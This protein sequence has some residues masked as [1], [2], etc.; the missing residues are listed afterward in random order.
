M[1]GLNLDVFIDICRRIMSSHHASAVYIKVHPVFTVRSLVNKRMQCRNAKGQILDHGKSFT[2]KLEITISIVF[3]LKPKTREALL[4]HR[5]FSPRDLAEAL[6]KAGAF[7]KGAMATS[8][9][10]GS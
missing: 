5:M 3:F 10:L 8:C 1:V 7:T 4:S 9:R 6:A 2:T